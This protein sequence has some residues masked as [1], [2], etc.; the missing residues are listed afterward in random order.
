MA[1]GTTAVSPPGLGHRAARGAAITFGGQAFRILLQVAS[2]VI[3]ARLLVPHDY[4]LIAMVMAVV[5]VADI[6]RDFGLSSAAIQAPSLSREQ[7]HN[8]FWINTGIG[9][10]LALLV[11]ALAPLLAGFYD[12][13]EL[14]G[15]ARVL[16]LTFLLNGV[17]TQYRADLNRRLRF[18]GI[19]LADTLSTLLALGVAVTMAL[20]G[21]G[22][23]ALVGQQVSQVATML[24]VVALSAGWLPRPPRRGVPMDGMLRF[25]WNYVGSQ[26]IG[27]AGNNVDAVII[28]ARFGAGPLGLYNRGFQLLMK[29]LG[30]LRAPTTTV[31]LPILAKLQDDQRRFGAF[32]A[33]GQLAL[34]YGLV[35]GLGLVAGAAEPVTRVFLGERWASVTPIIRLLAVAG[36]FQTLAFVGLWVYLSRALTRDLRR[37][38]LVS[39]LIRVACIAAGSQ[40]GVVGV[41]AG[42][43]LA[44]AI[45]WPLSFWWLS[46]RTP[47]PVRR[48]VLGGVRILGVT[49]VVGVAAFAATRALAAAPAWLALAAAAT[50]AL[51][52]CG[53]L[54]LLVPRVR[55]DVAAVADVARRAVAR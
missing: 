28:G 32:V 25:G 17:A 15:I 30:Q 53:L 31:A 11:V 54:A 38:T 45:A 19:A 37:Y 5:G 50:A 46:R 12:R 48:L 6:F 29:P 39:T 26:L 2:V 7:Q 41:A 42:Y 35:V 55:E 43:A 49:A 8:L 34:G 40:W 10:L 14:T 47:I 20:A 13:P 51:A 44:P 3:L 4:G 21:A 27:Y 36:A 24:V 16:A 33:R 1:R 23:W 52:A 18:G 22:Y 9:A